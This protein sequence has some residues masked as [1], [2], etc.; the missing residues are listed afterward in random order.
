[1]LPPRLHAP[2]LQKCSDIGV[3]SCG[4]SRFAKNIRIGSLRFVAGGISP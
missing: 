1:M 2:E 4:V 3:F